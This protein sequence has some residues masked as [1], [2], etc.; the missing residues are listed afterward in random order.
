[1]ILQKHNLGL[2]RFT[3]Q[4]VQIGISKTFL[5]CLERFGYHLF[6]HEQSFRVLP[7]PRRWNLIRCTRP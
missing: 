1:M 6:N 5:C 2:L 3:V 4:Y 7:P